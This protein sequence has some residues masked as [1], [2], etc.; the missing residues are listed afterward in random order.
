MKPSAA[1][2]FG[3]AEPGAPYMPGWS[4]MSGAAS[5]MFG[6]QNDIAA[7]PGI[8]V[9]AGSRKAQRG[10]PAVAVWTDTA[11][12]STDIG[13]STAPGLG[14]GIA[15]LAMSPGIGLRQTGTV[16]RIDTAAASDSGCADPE[17][18]WRDTVDPQGADLQ[19]TMLCSTAPFLS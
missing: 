14:S 16:A 4:C 8:A 6:F 12:W 11:E 19:T 13:I 2:S 3:I 5:Y 7:G 9:A 10:V 15:D 18:M 1:T 17:P